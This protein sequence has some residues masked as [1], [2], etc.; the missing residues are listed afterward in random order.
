MSTLFFVRKDLS[1]K[2]LGTMFPATMVF[3]GL[4]GPGSVRSWLDVA[5]LGYVVGAKPMPI[6]PITQLS[7]MRVDPCTKKGFVHILV[8]SDPHRWT[9]GTRV[10][11]TVLGVIPTRGWDEAIGDWD[12][13]CVGVRIARDAIL[14]LYDFLSFT[15]CD[16]SA[17][18]KGPTQ[19]EQPGSHK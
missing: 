2:G 6:I 1:G 13:T 9:I 17:L 12:F 14:V 5:P 10:K 19:I 4:A 11:G 18:P 3:T 8:E 15:A 7:S 16:S